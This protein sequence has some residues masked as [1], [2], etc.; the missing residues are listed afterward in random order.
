MTKNSTAV[1]FEPIY[2]YDMAEKAKCLLAS[3]ATG[4]NL[5]A[6]PLWSIH[7][8]GHHACGP[9]LRPLYQHDHMIALK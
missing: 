3:S 8:W 1:I 5:A 4:G 9:S 7:R 6:C 2:T